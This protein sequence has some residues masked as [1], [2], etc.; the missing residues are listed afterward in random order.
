VVSGGANDVT[1]LPPL[2]SEPPLE[3]VYQSIVHPLGA[4]ALKVTVPAPQR[5]L[6]LAPVGAAGTAFT[7]VVTAS[8]VADTHWV[9]VLRACA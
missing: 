5:E 4:V 2:T 8:R 3:A 1:P 9:V 6:A 7:V